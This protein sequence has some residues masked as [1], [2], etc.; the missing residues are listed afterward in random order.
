M[1]KKHKQAS[2]RR[3]IIVVLFALLI[4]ILI[5]LLGFSI[6]FA[7]MQRVRNEARVISDLSAKAAAD[8]LART[9]GDIDLARA[10]AKAVALENKIA[11]EFHQLKD[12]EIIFG[13]AALQ[14]NTGKWVFNAASTPF[15]SVKVN[16]RRNSASPKGRVRQFFGIFYGHPEFDLEQTATASFRDVEICLVL[17]RSISMKWKVNGPTSDSEKALA[18]CTV[19]NNVSRWH[20]LDI[21]IAEFIDTLRGTPVQER[22]AMVSFSSE[23]VTAC[24]TTSTVSTLDQSLTTNLNAIESS[25]NNY[26]TSVWF[27]GTNITAGL[28]QARLHMEAN[29]NA[30]RDRF[31]ILFTDGVATSGGAPFNEATACADAGIVVHTIT[32]GDTANTADMITTATNGGGEHN[33][34]AS[35]LELRTIFKRLAGSFAILTE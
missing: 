1:H 33:H 24:G 9:G 2:R 6:D 19:P 32:F 31:I 22:V 23:G 5:I 28:E 20:A 13:R 29:A 27:G 16:A 21:A 7:N 10:A 4:P 14:N 17:D 3:G 30:N 25:M 11:G 35:A 26:N 15:N 34:A 12:D 8:T 18:K